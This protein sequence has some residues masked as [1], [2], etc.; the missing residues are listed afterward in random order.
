MKKW[1]R[2]WGIAV[3]FGLIVLISAGWLLLADRIVKTTLETAATRVVGAKVDIGKADVSLLPTGLTLSG[4]QVTN[5]QRPMRN[6]LPPCRRRA[7]VTP[8]SPGSTGRSG[9]ISARPP[10]RKSLYP[11]WVK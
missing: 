1:F 10:L 11:S 5:P 2:W 4:L 8:P 3:F 7:S 9:L 6:A